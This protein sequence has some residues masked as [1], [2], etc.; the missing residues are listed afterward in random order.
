MMFPGSSMP[1]FHTSVLLKTK[2][3]LKGWFCRAAGIWGRGKKQ[4]AGEPPKDF[5]NG[6]PSA[7]NFVKVSSSFEADHAPG[8]NEKPFTIF[9][10]SAG[11]GGTLDH[12]KGTESRNGHLAALSQRRAD[13]GKES[14]DHLMSS[15]LADFVGISDSNDK[16]CFVHFDLL[17]FLAIFTLF[18]KSVMRICHSGLIWKGHFAAQLLGQSRIF[19][20]S[21]KID[22]GTKVNTKILPIYLLYK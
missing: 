14:A 3:L 11:A 10:V 21:I 19:S 2:E 4:G 5:Y 18:K 22:R 7:N 9:R 8:R 15:S 17:L 6:G 20:V 16:I 12:R 1:H 13:C